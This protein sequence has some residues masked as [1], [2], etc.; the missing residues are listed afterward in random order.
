[1][2]A[3]G[4]VGIGRGTTGIG[5]GRRSPAPCPTTNCGGGLAS[6][7]GA[8]G[9]SLRVRCFGSRSCTPSSGMLS[10]I[11]GHAERAG[12]LTP[13]EYN[14]PPVSDHLVPESATSVPRP[15][16]DRGRALG[17][18][19]GDSLGSCNI[20]SGV[21]SDRGR[22][23]GWICGDPGSAHV[24]GYAVARSRPAGGRR[25]AGGWPAGGRAAGTRNSS[26]KFGSRTLSGSRPG[27]CR[28]RA[29]IPL[30][31]LANVPPTSISEPSAPDSGLRPGSEQ[32]DRPE[33]PR[34]ALPVAH[35]RGK[36][37]RGRDGRCEG[38]I[39]LVINA[40][41]WSG[42]EHP[43]VDSRPPTACWPTARARAFA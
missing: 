27:A 4:R 43:P 17:W 7:T 26:S 23:L 11:L 18:I 14:G 30:L 2:L 21:N 31:I 40:P 12:T 33:P 24:G 38:A 39:F 29:Q 16:L 36:Q 22:A 8:D 9:S 35:W 32:R 5:R 6:P 25:V 10:A 1:M 42:S 37:G 13:P 41:G 20:Q 28:R 19:C 3:G 34:S 15:S